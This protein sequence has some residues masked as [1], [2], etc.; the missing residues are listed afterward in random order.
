[1]TLIG[2]LSIKQR[3]IT[4][5]VKIVEPFPAYDICPIR[6][7]NAMPIE[8]SNLSMVTYEFFCDVIS[9]LATLHSSLR[10]RSDRTCVQQSKTVYSSFRQ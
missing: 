10:R 7:V 9:C 2:H 6:Y 5:H 4:V 1:V 3:C 8:F